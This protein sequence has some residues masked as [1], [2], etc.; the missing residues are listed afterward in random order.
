MEVLDKVFAGENIGYTIDD[1]HIILYKS[2]DSNL[3]PQVS[4]QTGRIITGIVTDANA[5]PIIGANVIE[6]GT[7][8]GTITDID[9]KFSLNILQNSVLQISYIGYLGQEIPV[10]NQTNVRI[11]LKENLQ[12]LDEIVVVGYGIAQ[13][14]DL[15]G[16]ISQVQSDDLQNLA[17]SRVDQALSGKLAGVQVVS[18]TGEPGAAP[19]IRIRGVGSIS[20]GTEPL[21]VIDGFPG[22]N[23]QMINPNDIETIDILKDASATAIYG[24]RGANG[25]VIITTKRGKEGKN[26]IN[27]NVYYGWQKVL[28][29]PEFLTKEEQAWYYYDGIKNQNLDANRDINGNPL[30]DWFYQVPQTIMDVINGTNKYNTDAYDEIF[31]T[32]P[33]QSYNLSTLG[34]T[35]KLRYAV[36]G[37][38]MAQDGIII[39]N[40]FRRY[41]LRANLDSQL[42]ERIA[43]K[44]NI[45][46]VYSTG[47]NILAS[48]GAA[49]SEGILGAATTWLKWYPLYNED[50]T[51]YSGFGQDATNN[52]WN[53]VAQAYE[54]IR[55]NEQYRTLANLNTEFE[56][57]NNIKLNIMAG[58][59][60][61]NRHYYSFIP[62]LDVFN[63]TADG[64]DE[65]SNNLNWITESTLNY[66][67]SI[68][69]IHNV[70]GLIGY[71]TQK[72]ENNSNYIRSR[73]YPNNLVY[74]LNAVSND[75]YQ[76]NSDESEW[77]LI[78]YLARINY[79]YNSKYY[80]TTSIRSDGSSRFGREKKYGYFPSA[81]LAWRVSE[82]EFI[83]EISL[84]SNLKIRASYGETGNNNIGNYAHLATVGYE[85][86]VFG[87]TAIGGVSPSNI[88]NA[89]LTWEKQSSLN[90]GL[91]A[92]LFD[93]R[94]NLTVDYFRTKNYELLLNVYVPQ[95]TGFNTSL[96]NIGEVENSGWEFTL[97]TLNFS[98]VF[99]WNT[100]FN[101]S[102][103]KNKVLKL[104]PEGAPI[105]ST[106]HITQIG[107][108]MG[109]FYGYITDG[110]FMNQVELDAGPIWAPGTSD[111]S[112]VGDVRFKDVS[113]PE[114]IPDGIINT[115]DRAIMGS[116][117]PDFYYGMINSFSYKNIGLSFS[118]QGSYGNKVFNT[119]DTQMYTRA[120]YK[121]YAV[122]KNYWKSE[123]EPGD[124]ESP[125]PNNLPTGG[126]RQKSTR[127]LDDGSYLKINN[128]NLSY[129]FPT[130]MIE[131]LSLSSLRIYL[132]A[133]N[134]F[135][136]TKFR[137][138]NPEVSSSTNPLTPGQMNYNYP[139]AKSLIMGINV[140]F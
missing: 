131:K 63:N 58:I 87:N 109:M 140:S 11:V 1:K 32:A 24:S 55:R 16:S 137:D 107:Q 42:S 106:N 132:T 33:Q 90:F 74:T 66:Q 76:G 29:T 39:T 30:V 88:E 53:P 138:F 128:I 83:K 38:Y 111:R 117:Y 17:I 97:N 93:N 119:S 71:T 126:V 85:S 139:I 21:Y 86:Y 3:V 89:L 40:N 72:Q 100:D 26:K 56:I 35:N 37:E 129:T 67:K 68:N 108:P 113:G 52:V 82:E 105:I 70:S 18:T 65:R 9:G 73:S 50:G 110:I 34:G 121:Q 69:N 54:I 123:S 116:P 81:A 120:R 6:K 43:V 27:L 95:I 99:E 130:R 8:N 133:T 2:D 75:I 118:I 64:T 96:Q 80:I 134:P 104:G 45:N 46:S 25:V 61:S 59:S 20:A 102:A 122:V 91:D 92:S 60:T 41:S 47:K 57:T 44:F 112:H 62:K 48:G 13:K 101:I 28:K 135:I 14:K 84:I 22:D 79:N 127:Y 49:E 78:S 19:L 136:I 103:F 114:G 23:I 125:R 5:E 15:T 94:I 4:Q 7:N 98:G 36:S 77:S 12:T 51:Y 115:Y 31:Q 124:G 10:R